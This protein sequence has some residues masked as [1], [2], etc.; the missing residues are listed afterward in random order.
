M[1]AFTASAV[2]APCAAK[3]L[4]SR[5]S[6]AARTPAMAVKRVAN[7]ANKRAPLSVAAKAGPSGEVKK[8]RDRAIRNSFARPDARGDGA[9]RPHPGSAPPPRNEST[10]KPCSPRF[11]V[12]SVPS[13]SR[14]TAA[15]SSSPDLTRPFRPALH[16]ETGRAR[17]L[18]R[19]R[20]LH[21]PQ[22]A[23]G[24]LRLRGDHL[25]RRPRPGRGARAR[26]RQG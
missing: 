12:P 4:A 7:K 13:P 1:S 17:V 26:A 11:V 5:R 24:Y 22:V 9:E 20:H 15:A 16:P 23:P 18:R 19:P 8:V 3:L 21:H 14:E 2:A 10:L 6:V 25:H